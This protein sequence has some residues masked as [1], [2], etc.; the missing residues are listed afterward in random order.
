MLPSAKRIDR[1]LGFNFKKSLFYGVPNFYNLRHN[2]VY[3]SCSQVVFA[4]RCYAYK[5]GIYTV[6]RCRL[7][8]CGGVLLLSRCCCVVSRTFIPPRKLQSVRVSVMFVYSVE[9]SKHI[10]IF[11]PSGSHTIL[12]FPVPNVLAVF[13]QG[14]PNGGVEYR[15]GRQKSRFS[16]IACRQH[17]DGGV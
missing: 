15:W 16:T 14:P 11:S 13:R 10:S 12:V 5:R 6:V 9:T 2:D 3:T 17:F 1:H 4:A 7:K 8:R